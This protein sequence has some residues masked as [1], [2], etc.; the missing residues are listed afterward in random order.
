LVYAAVKIITRPR[1]GCGARDSSAL[2]H[3]DSGNL[4]RCGNVSSIM[5]AVQ[6]RNTTF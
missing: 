2:S 5:R 6:A 4:S 1:C 3:V